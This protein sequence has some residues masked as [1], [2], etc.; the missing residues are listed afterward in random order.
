VALDDGLKIKV[1]LGE[2]FNF[3]REFDVRVP[4]ITTRVMPPEN[5]KKFFE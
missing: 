5:S 4:V 3:N 2:R 1:H